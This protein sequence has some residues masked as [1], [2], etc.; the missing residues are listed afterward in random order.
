MID[1]RDWLW[2]CQD[3][4]IECQSCHMMSTLGGYLA[5]ET[6][7]NNPDEVMADLCD[8]DVPFKIYVGDA[9]KEHI[10][11]LAYLLDVMEILHGETDEQ[12]PE[13]SATMSEDVT[14]TRDLWIEQTR[15]DLR[16]E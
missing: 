13:G 5:P 10:G 1:P 8:C 4:P 15:D 6:D 9:P 16:D 3:V 12:T 11:K 2:E 14:T 7:I